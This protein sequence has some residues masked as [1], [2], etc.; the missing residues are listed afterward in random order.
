MNSALRLWAPILAVSFVLA[1]LA[2]SA[3]ADAIYTYSDPGDLSWSFEVPAI[4]TTTTTITS[5]LS[6]NVVTGGT[7]DNLG[8]TSINS[9]SISFPTSSFPSVS[10][11]FSDCIFNFGVA[12]NELIDHFGTFQDSKGAPVFLTISPS[13]VP[14]PATLLLLAGG[15]ASFVGL[16]RKRIR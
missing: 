12:F 15:L 13:G 9:V 10:A 14:E 3:K 5:F 1:A 16:R 2:P 11:A 7:A 4:I 6:T 8:C